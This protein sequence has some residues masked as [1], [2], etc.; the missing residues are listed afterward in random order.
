MADVDAKRRLRYLGKRKVILKQ[1]GAQLRAGMADLGKSL[2]A[3]TDP[4]Q[5]REFSDSVFYRK[6]R[7]AEIREEISKLNAE[8]VKLRGA[9]APKPK[10]K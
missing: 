8:T 4:K 7:I 1:E 9:V 5:K 6:S 3:A 2:R 10:A